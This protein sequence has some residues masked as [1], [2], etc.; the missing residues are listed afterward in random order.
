MNRN[1]KIALRWPALFVAAFALWMSPHFS[2]AAQ[3]ERKPATAAAAT[4]GNSAAVPAAGHAGSAPAG[5]LD[6]RIPLRDKS[7]RFAVIGDSGTG[8]RSQYEVAQQMEAYWQATKFEFVIMLGDNIYGGHSPRDFTRKFEQ[9]YKELLDS[10]VKFYASLGNHD[11]PNTERL[12]K[13]FNMNGERYYAF[14]KGEVAF[15]ALDS[16]YMDPN[17]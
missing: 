2:V 1:I 15:F 3:T 17:Q 5:S 8:E 7:V 4:N 14:R 12:Y 11:D 16:N 6:I 9:P 13:P 10:G